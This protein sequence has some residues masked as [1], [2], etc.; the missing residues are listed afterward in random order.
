MKVYVPAGSGFHLDARTT[1]GSVSCDLPLASVTEQTR[2][3]IDAVVGTQGGHV[4]LSTTNGS[5]VIATVG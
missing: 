2:R 4:K 1:N 3:R 5:V